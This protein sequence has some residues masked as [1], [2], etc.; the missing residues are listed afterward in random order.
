MKRTL[1]LAILGVAASATAFG[2]GGVYIDNGVSDSYGVYHPVV[3]ADTGAG[4]HSTDG[5]QLYAWYGEGA[6]LTANQLTQ[7]P[8]VQWSTVFE[9]YGYY[10][11]YNPVTITLPTWTAGDTFTFQLRASGNSIYGP[12]DTIRSRSVLWEENSNIGFIGGT[13][14]G[15]PGMS[16]NRIGFSVYIV[17]E[18]SAMALIGLGIV[19]MMTCRRRA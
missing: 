1:V 13:P 19:A 12:V 16:N 15:L 7:G 4:V 3:W 14:P 17:P 18:P 2:Q 5:V 11:Y 8:S 10:G 9:S 6:G